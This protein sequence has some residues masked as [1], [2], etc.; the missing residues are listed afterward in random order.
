MLRC[1]S[2][3]DD[4]VIIVE[5]GAVTGEGSADQSNERGESGEGDDGEE[6]NFDH[7]RV[8]CVFL[9]FRNGI[10][11]IAPRFETNVRLER[12]ALLE[13][14]HDGGLGR[15]SIG[16]FQPIAG[17]VEVRLREALNIVRP[18]AELVVEGRLCWAARC[19]V[20]SADAVAVVCTVA[21]KIVGILVASLGDGV[22]ALNRSLGEAPFQIRNG[23]AFWVRSEIT[24]A[25][26]RNGEE[27]S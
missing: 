20:A 26:V 4:F 2:D 17:F 11:T 9:G 22:V 16:Q 12:I 10:F 13:E 14:L 18:I 6:N 8:R 5:V 23:F 15:V 19:V 7:F 24:E 27:I 21:I 1:E 3:V 25:S